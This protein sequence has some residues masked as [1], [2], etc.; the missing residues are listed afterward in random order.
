MPGGKLGPAEAAVV[1][2]GGQQHAGGAGPGE[3]G[4]IGAAAHAARR[5]EA[6][7]R[8]PPAQGGE[9]FQVRAAAATHP[10]QVHDDDIPGPERG[11]FQQG[12][13]TEEFVAAKIQGQD[14]LCVQT[15]RLPLVQAFAAEYRP[16]R[17]GAQGA[18]EAARVHPEFKRR[19]GPAQ[20][21]DDSAMIAPRQDRIQVGDVAATKR[22][23]FQQAVQH[24]RRLARSAQGGN[25]RAVF[26][27]PALPGMHHPAAHQVE[28]GYQAQR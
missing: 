12:A 25:Q 6:P 19:M 3:G 1:Q 11:A 23:Q 4:Q 2:G 24:R 18:G 28:H 9:A 5:V 8:R 7:V 14:G 10:F 16:D 20:C 22:M 27:A 15:G 21:G 13:R 17:G 26:V